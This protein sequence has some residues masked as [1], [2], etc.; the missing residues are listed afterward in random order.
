M[1]TPIVSVDGTENGRQYPVENPYHSDGDRRLDKAHDGGDQHPRQRHHYRGRQKDY[2]DLLE[3]FSGFVIHIAHLN[4]CK[5]DIIIP[6]GELWRD[7]E[8]SQSLA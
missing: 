2:A 7:A 1:A 8:L 3:Q 6:P 5:I 4:L